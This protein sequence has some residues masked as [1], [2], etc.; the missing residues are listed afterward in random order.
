MKHRHA[1]SI[2]LSVFFALLLFLV[3]GAPHARAAT[4]F[5]DSPLLLS[6]ESPQDGDTVTLSVLFHNAESEPISGS[7]LFYDGQTLLDK[8]AV[9]IDPGAVDIASTTFVI[10]AGIHTF[11]ATMSSIDETDS[12]GKQQV[13]VIPNSTVKLPA[14]LVTRKIAPPVAQADGSSDDSADS[15]SSVILDKVDAA[16]NAVLN[17]VPAG[18]KTAVTSSVTS[19]DGW[20]TSVAASLTSSANA[21]NASIQAGKKI[22]AANAALKP[23]KKPEAKPATADDGPFSVLKYVVLAGLAFFFSTPLVFYLGGLIILY[24]II[25]FIFRRIRKAR[26]NKGR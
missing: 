15:S 5:V 2:F 14:D 10:Q 8:K 13:V 22:D 1:A 17:A 11:S 3:P 26:A 23:G 6:P 16:Q 20:R 24:L 19:V 7:V 4:G 9:S 25:R 12:T 21:A 18:A